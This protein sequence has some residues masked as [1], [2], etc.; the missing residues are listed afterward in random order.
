MLE[1][2]CRLRTR[3]DRVIFMYVPAH[4]GIASNAYA[5]ATAKTYWH[6]PWSTATAHTVCTNVLS[7]P[8]LYQS[9]SD[10]TPEGY[11]RQY[12]DPP[13]AWVLQDRRLFR[14]TRMRC[15]RWIDKHLAAPLSG[16]CLLTHTHIGRRSHDCETDT[17]LA[18]AKL[19]LGKPLHK[20]E[21]DPIN[22][23]ATDRARQHTVAY[24]RQ[25][26]VAD[27]PGAH[28]EWWLR[29]RRTEVRRRTV[30]PATRHG[31]RGTLRMLPPTHTPTD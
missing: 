30:G 23:M 17:Y 9:P 31:R 24:A 7:R 20:D 22:R 25:G 6:Q 4:A 16:H 21:T 13:T 28:D 2:I 11:L 10:F 5:D 3:F 19:G 27:V 15:G 12:E 8:S 29:A 1:A 26:K 18:I 14:N